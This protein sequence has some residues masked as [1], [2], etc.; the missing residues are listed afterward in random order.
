MYYKVSRIIRDIKFLSIQGAREVAK[1]SLECFILTA[2][3]SK[4]KSRN[5]FM[6]EI[7]GLVSVFVK[8]RPT[9]PMLKNVIASVMLKLNNYDGDN[10]K[11]VTVN[12]CKDEIG[13]INQALISIA[14]IVNGLNV[15]IMVDNKFSIA[16]I[17]SGSAEVRYAV[18]L[19]LSIM[20]QSFWSWKRIL[21]ISSLLMPCLWKTVLP[22][23]G[24]S[25]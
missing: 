9:E 24:R 6:K 5:E 19:Q 2:K 16:L 25:E 11:S 21:N 20:L 23:T 8:T 14:E 18:P 12:L 10:F 4:A 3:Y 17:M 15:L 22:L 7:K 1:A 13:R